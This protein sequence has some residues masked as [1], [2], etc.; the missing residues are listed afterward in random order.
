ML[1][2]L[3]N[4]TRCDAEHVCMWELS[5]LTDNFLYGSDKQTG[6]VNRK[7]QGQSGKLVSVVKLWC[8]IVVYFSCKVSRQ[9]V[10]KIYLVYLWVFLDHLYA[11]VGFVTFLY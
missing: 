10:T 11:S 3:T 4:S 9:E 7:F 8:Y 5:I 6:K 1:F 2:I